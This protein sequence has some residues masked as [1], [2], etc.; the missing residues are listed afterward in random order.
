MTILKSYILIFVAAFFA[1]QFI[2]SRMEAT[3]DF[4]S[5]KT[6]TFGDE[7]A[8]VSN[9][10]ASVISIVAIFL[11]W[12]AFTGSKLTPIHAPGPFVGDTTFT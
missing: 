9:R 7:S 10:W 4:T 1:V 12:G 11:I 6:V 3:K 2:T 5:L 8:V